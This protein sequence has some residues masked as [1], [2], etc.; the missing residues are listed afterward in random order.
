MHAAPGSDLGLVP[1]SRLPAMAH[2][3]TAPKSIVRS[4]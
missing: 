2:S 3:G 4:P 1:C